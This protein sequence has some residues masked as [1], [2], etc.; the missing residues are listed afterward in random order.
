M[1]AVDPEFVVQVRAGGHAGAADVADDRALRDALALADIAEA[2]HVAVEGGVAAAVVQDHRA[3]VAA[4]PADQLHAGIAGRLD[5][6]AGGRGVVHAL[7]HAGRA[8]HRMP[9]TAEA[10]RQT[11]V[12]NRHAD[13]AFLQRPT[14][15]GEVFGFAVADVAE[16]GVQ[17]AVDGE[18]RGQHR[19]G[20]LQFAVDPHLVDHHAEEVVGVEVGIEVD[21]V[22]EDFVG[23]LV[24]VP[25]AQPELARRTEQR[26]ADLAA[27]HHGAHVDIA[28]QHGLAHAVVGEFQLDA[29]AVAAHEAHRAQLAVDR[30]IHRQ[31]GLGSDLADRGLRARMRQHARQVG[32]GDAQLFEQ[33]LER[34]AAADGDRL[35]A[36]AQ[37]AL[38]PRQR[39]RREFQRQGLD[40]RGRRG[41][42]Y[43]IEAGD[44]GAQQRD[45]GGDQAGL[46]PLPP[47]PAPVEALGGGV[48]GQD[49]VGFL[50]GGLVQIAQANEA[51]T[52][53]ATRR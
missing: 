5:G 52:Q 22:L 32:G 40:G 6:R 34:G 23:E 4:V 29:L 51:I 26:A 27:E 31:L 25:T 1:N 15:C 50:L 44:D 38:L 2:R 9:A 13:E 10:R 18:G 37:V 36:V 39:Q 21:V 43:G 28:A 53:G 16:A 17:L 24:E 46:R 20:L 8:Q 41:L 11:G 45:H 14:V 35:P 19:A 30:Q 3:A 49:L 33:M 48:F 12:G 7:V 42:Q 47:R